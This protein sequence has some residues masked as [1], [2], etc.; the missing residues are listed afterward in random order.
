VFVDEPPAKDH[1][2]LS[3][4]QVIATPHL[5]A[6]TEEAQE[7]V[8]VEVAEQIAAFLLRGEVRNAVNLPPLSGELQAR[9]VPYLDLARR[10]GRLVAQLGAADAGGLEGVEIEVAGEAG[11]LG[12]GPIAA[13]A[14]AGL[15]ERHLDVPVNEV[16]ALLL[17]AERGLRVSEIKR[18]HGADFTS[19]VSLRTAGRGRAARFVRGTVFRTGEGFEPRVVQI[20]RFLLEAVPDGRMIVLANQDRPGVIGAVGTLLGRRGIN[21]SRMQV[22]LDRATGEALQVWNVD[23]AVDAATLDAVRSVAFVGSAALVEL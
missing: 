12:A 16:N 15:L 13:A 14:V 3:L 7:K 10:I 2:L 19:S 6:S 22:G 21:V 5:G 18:P 9:L 8:A 11:D 17:A 1:P 4:E 20:D 23:G